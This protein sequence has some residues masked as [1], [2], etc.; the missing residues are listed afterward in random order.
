MI[1][2]A[3]QAIWISG[4]TLDLFSRY[5][6]VLKSALQR[7][8]PLDIQLLMLDLD[9]QVANEVGAWTGVNREI[10][11]KPNP[12]FDDWA[13]HQTPAITPEGRWVAQ[14]LVEN[15]QVLEEIH[16]QAPDRIEI[17]TISHR[18]GT[19]FFIID[20]NLED[21]MLTATPYVY[22]IDRLKESLPPAYYTSPIFLS[23]RSF[24]ESDLWW[25][26]QYVN[27]FLRLWEAATIWKP[28]IRP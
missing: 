24:N 21:G 20:P 1:N 28:R 5:R 23:R 12:A 18:L 11:L 4:L 15:R 27:E 3:R 10:K 17:R 25:F 22:Q 26:D 2:E 14:R 7:E 6:D 19:G 8:P 9:V 16:Q 13:S